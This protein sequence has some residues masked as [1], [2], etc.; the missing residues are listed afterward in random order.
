LARSRA[1]RS[2]FTLVELM[3]AMCGGL[4][5]S[6]AVMALTRDFSRFSMQQM[7][8]SNATL[9]GANGFDR[10]VND[11]ARTGYLVTPNINSDPRVCNR[12]IAGWPALLG[13]LRAL[14]LNTTGASAAN[15]EVSRAGI[16]PMSVT[17]AGALDMGEE[18]TITAVSVTGGQNMVGIRVDTPAAARIGLSATNPAN[19]ATILGNIF[20]PGGVGRAIRISQND[21]LEQYAVVAAINQNPLQLQLAAIPAIQ[22]RAN[23]SATQCGVLGHCTGCTVNVINFVRY[24]LRSLN[25]APGA[26]AELFNASAESNLPYEAGRVEL[27][28]DE[29]DPGGTVLA[30]TSELVAEYATDLQFTIIQ[31]T[32]PNNPTLFNPLPAAINGT[33]P[34]TQLIRG[35][36][37]RL[38]VRSREAD[39]GADVF[40][41]APGQYRISLQGSG[42]TSAAQYGFARVRSLQADV[43]VRNLEGANWN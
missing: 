24:E 18:L 37:A 32:G 29:L 8:I 43:A 21:G 25:A 19:N 23:A 16:T 1:G 27:M 36:R 22:Y 30:G 33:Y 4:F 31:A 13:Q 28:R 40:G 14:T 3:V 9:A 17:I 7:R 12:P 26:Y 38:A 2:G 34:S 15:T 10:L 41:A 42:G 11:L 6:L 20:L 39:R 35:I 5:L